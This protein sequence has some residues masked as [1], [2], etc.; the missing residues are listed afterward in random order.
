[1]N[2]KKEESEFKQFLL[3][4]CNVVFLESTVLKHMRPSQTD[5]D[6]IVRNKFKLSLLK[7][8]YENNLT[9]NFSC[10]AMRSY[11]F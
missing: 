8:I 6:I 2:D 9:L 5:F 11:Y 10:Y 1:M 7:A 4:V 3:D